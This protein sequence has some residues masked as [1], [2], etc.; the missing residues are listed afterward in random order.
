VT[1]LIP[2][3]GLIPTDDLPIEA[4]ISIHRYSG[5]IEYN[6]YLLVFLSPLFDLRTLIRFATGQARNTD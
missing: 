6:F 3:T 4:G 2:T 5:N 1:D